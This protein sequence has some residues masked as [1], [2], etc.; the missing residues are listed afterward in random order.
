VDCA[1]S[2]SIFKLLRQARYFLPSRVRLTLPKSLYCPNA[3]AQSNSSQSPELAREHGN[4]ATP[5]VSSGQ[6]S[7]PSI[8]TPHPVD[9]YPWANEAL[10]KA[11]KETSR[12]FFPS[13]YFTCH[14]CHVH[15]A[16]N[17]IPIQHRRYPEAVFRFYQSDRE[18]GPILTG[19]YIA[20]VEATTGSAGWPLNVVLTPRAQAFFRRTYFPRS[21]TQVAL[22]KGRRLVENTTRFNHS[23]RR[24]RRTANSF[25]WSSK[26]PPATRSTTRNS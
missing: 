4:T 7:L 20:Y 23:D 8:C 25:R 6:E 22:R 3:P 14:W 5:T 11:R 2:A 17:R 16:G 19:L 9:W 10:K 21:Q 18:D 15:G 1:N 12:S 13:G 24:E 26:Q